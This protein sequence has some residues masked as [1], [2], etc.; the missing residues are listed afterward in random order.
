[1]N[2]MTG[3]LGAAAPYLKLLVQSHSVVLSGSTIQDGDHSLTTRLR[4]MFPQC[5]TPF[6][7]SRRPFGGRI[8]WWCEPFGIFP[9]WPVVLFYC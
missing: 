7:A 2:T 6:F 1:M 9:F 5:T 4:S 3:A 8:A